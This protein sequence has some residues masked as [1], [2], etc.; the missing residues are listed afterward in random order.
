VCN[1]ALAHITV[2]DAGGMALHAHVLRHLHPVVYGAVRC[3]VLV[4]L[5]PD[6]MLWRVLLW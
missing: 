4:S 2:S 5:P 1:D 3:V 6:L